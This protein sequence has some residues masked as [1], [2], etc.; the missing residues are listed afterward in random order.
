MSYENFSC[1]INVSDDSLSEIYWIVGDPDDF[2]LTTGNGYAV[3]VIV[4]LFL[5][6]GLPW[7]LFVVCA[8]IKKRLY[9]QPVIT[10]MLNL[11]I[12]NLLLYILVMPF[13]IVT[14]IAGEYVFGETDLVRCRVCQ[15]GV[16]V[17][18]L[19]GVTVNTLCL[20]SIDRF[21]YLKKPLRYAEIVT[22]RRTLAAIISAWLL[23][24]A[25]SIPPLVGFGEI[26][27]AYVA[28]TCAPLFVGSTH[29]AP[30]YYYMLLLLAVGIVPII[31]LITLYFWIMCIVRNSLIWKLRRSALN[32]DTARD[33]SERQN[34]LNKKQ[35]KMFGV[36]FTANL[37]TWLPIIVVVLAAAIL[38]S[39][40]V[41]AVVYSIAY[42][43]YLSE[44]VIHA[45]LSA[46]FIPQLK[47]IVS[48]VIALIRSKL[49][50][51]LEC[52]Y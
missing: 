6:L 52:V 28:A 27:F 40:G 19:P 48:E 39:G 45:V 23:C 20:M 4:S 32:G 22:P 31:T 46:L 21:I 2:E 36:I 9:S 8:I 14:G 42:L 30:N 44:T 49:V 11:A 37:V 41:P 43:L 18:M 3:A 5:L 24:I 47:T 16:A 7:N 35:L 33:Q 38:G 12:T 13:N 1:L 51:I 17:I 50:G 26:R 10:L 25:I 15:T 29:I 34:T